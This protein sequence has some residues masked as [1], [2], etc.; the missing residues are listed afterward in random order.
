MKEISK[1][2]LWLDMI[3]DFMRIILAYRFITKE[4]SF[5]AAMGGIKI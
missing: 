5:M 4:I 3:D 2:P 1:C